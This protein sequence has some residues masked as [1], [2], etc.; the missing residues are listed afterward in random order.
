LNQLK[1][2]DLSKD[3]A[4]LN[5]RPILFWHGAKNDVVPIT[6]SEEFVAKLKNSTYT[7]E[8]E[9]LKELNRDHH[10]SRYSILEAV[11]W[12]VKHLYNNFKHKGLKLYVYM[13]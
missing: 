10:L 6:H 7:G 13:V 4:S 8:V 11:K 12:F 1:P 3:M 9:M 2:F 5:N